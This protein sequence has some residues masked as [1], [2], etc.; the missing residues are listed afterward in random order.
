MKNGTKRAAPR[1]MPHREKP[2]R[3]RE[4]REIEKRLKGD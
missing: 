3:K 2:S 1:G 4:K